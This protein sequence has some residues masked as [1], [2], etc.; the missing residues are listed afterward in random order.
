MLVAV[1][2]IFKCQIQN[3]HLLLDYKWLPF[4][5]PRRTYMVNTSK[6]HGFLLF[7]VCIFIWSAIGSNTHWY[8][9]LN[10]YSQELNKT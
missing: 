6:V 3:K 9:R 5:Y 10:K 2:G 7:S 4:K 8:Q 1:D